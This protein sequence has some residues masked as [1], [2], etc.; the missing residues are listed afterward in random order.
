MA[1]KQ[2]FVAAAGS[3]R[4][5]AALTRVA[6]RR[7]AHAQTQAE[8]PHGFAEQLRIDFRVKL[9]K[10]RNSMAAFCVHRHLAFAHAA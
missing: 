7:L 3:K 9:G 8:V 5:N 10:L 2:R 6:T 4:T 1:G